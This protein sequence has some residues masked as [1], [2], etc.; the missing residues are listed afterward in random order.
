MMINKNDNIYVKKPEIVEKIEYKYTIPENKYYISQDN[1]PEYKKK[2][3]QSNAQLGYNKHIE[4]KKIKE[5][6]EK[7]IGFMNFLDYAGLATGATGLAKKGLTKG[8]K[9]AVKGAAKDAAKK[10]IDNLN[11]SAA[12]KLTMEEMRTISGGSKYPANIRRNQKN[13]DKAL[14]ERIPK[15]PGETYSDLEKA[16]LEKLKQAGVDISNISKG[17]INKLFNLKQKEILKYNK[18]GRVN[19]INQSKDDNGKDVLTSIDAQF[20]NGKKRFV[21]Y[22]DYKKLDDGLN[23]NFVTNYD[24]KPPVKGVYERG[25]NSGI[26]LSRALK[27]PGVVSGKHLMSKSKTYKVWDKYNTKQD[28]GDIGVHTNVNLGEIGEADGHAYKIMRPSELETITKSV[29]IDPKIIN[30]NGKIKIDWNSDDIFKIIG[31]PLILGAK[32]EDK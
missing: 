20:L 13:I 32:N 10:N 2:Q 21:G 3:D 5:G 4:D 16:Q 12:T 23:I 9:M 30:K 14:G 17:D 29:M 26:K 19:I 8:I 6:T 24:V 27:D 18:N 1:R 31:T 11:K 22:T 28:L 7:L 15:I 25:I